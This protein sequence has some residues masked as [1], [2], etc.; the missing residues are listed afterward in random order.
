MTVVLFGVGK[1]SFDPLSMDHFNPTNAVSTCYMVCNGKIL[2]LK[3]NDG[4]TAGNRWC[5]PG[6]KLKKNETPLQ[7]VIREIKE[8]TNI[9][10]LPEEA[11]FIH[12]ICIRIRNPKQD[13]LLHLF[14][15]VLPRSQPSDYTIMLNQEHTDHLWADLQTAKQLNLVAGGKEILDLLHTTTRW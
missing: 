15:A 4:A 12:T 1:F 5:M 8:E 3:R 2:L 14:K 9:L 11:D 7:A 10:L 6:G 13:Y